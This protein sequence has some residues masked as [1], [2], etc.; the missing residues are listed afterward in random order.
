LDRCIGCYSDVLPLN[1]VSSES[2][3]RH[4]LPALLATHFLSDHTV[5][6]LSG[7]QIFGGDSTR[8]VDGDGRNAQGLHFIGL[9]RVVLA[10]QYRVRLVFLLQSLLLCL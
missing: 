7:V 6:T 4:D 3:T 1:I 10:I 8:A 2:F 9:G 5:R